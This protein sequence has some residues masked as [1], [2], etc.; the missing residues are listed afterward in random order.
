M[1]KLTA[2]PSEQSSHKNQL[3]QIH[4]KENTGVDHNHLASMEEEDGKEEDEDHK[5]GIMLERSE[6]NA[7]DYCE[8]SSGGGMS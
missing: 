6:E 7:T 2:V 5:T 3:L 8:E 1:D 4:N